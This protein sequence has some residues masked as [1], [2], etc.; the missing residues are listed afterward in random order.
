MK[1]FCCQSCKINIIGFNTFNKMMLSKISSKTQNIVS[2]LLC[3]EEYT[4]MKQVVHYEHL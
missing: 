4:F 2:F 3:V 1:K